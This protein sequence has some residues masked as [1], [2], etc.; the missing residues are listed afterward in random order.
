MDGF[1]EK[2]INPEKILEQLKR[3][4]P[5][6]IRSKANSK[7][8]PQLQLVRRELPL[9]NEINFETCRMLATIHQ[10]SL[11]QEVEREIL[12][13]C[14]RL[15]E[16]MQEAMN[17]S[18]LQTARAAAHQVKNL[19]QVVQS[20]ETV[21]FFG[22]LQQAIDLNDSEQLSTLQ[23]SLP[24]VCEHFRQLLQAYLDFED[25]PSDHGI[26]SGEAPPPFSPS[27]AGETN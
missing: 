23:Q 2:P 4:C 20:T 16:F 5:H 9:H 27:T 11:R 8:S 6:M 10:N 1:I 13:P 25:T 19:V 15:F 22:N 24:S 12:E 21:A 18:D 14:N 7:S 17:A 3:L 26:S